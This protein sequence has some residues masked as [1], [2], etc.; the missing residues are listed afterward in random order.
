MPK[1]ILG[2]CL[3][4]LAGCYGRD[5]YDEIAE[6]KTA[7]VFACGDNW[8]DAQLEQIANAFD[9]WLAQGITLPSGNEPISFGGHNSGADPQEGHCI[10]KVGPDN[11]VAW[12]TQAVENDRKAFFDQSSEEIVFLDSGLCDQSEP[13]F[14]CMFVDI[15]PTVAHELGHGMGLGHSC[16][17]DDECSGMESL[18]EGVAAHA[19]TPQPMDV[20][21]ECDRNGCLK[22]P[23]R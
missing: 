14:L 4:V 2:I 11:E 7:K 23:L 5:G 13:P 10:R 18:M 16:E 22:P 8:R 6:G 15:G 17:G 9:V 19:S 12:Q 20:Q 21:A 3:A 1:W